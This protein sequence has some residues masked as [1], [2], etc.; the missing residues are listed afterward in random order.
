MGHLLKGDEASR[1]HL[2][3]GVRHGEHVLGDVVTLSGPVTGDV[4]STDSGLNGGESGERRSRDAAVS[5]IS[6]S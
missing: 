1:V 4:T 5:P 2:V 6:L 3:T